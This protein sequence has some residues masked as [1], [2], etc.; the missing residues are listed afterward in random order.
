MAQPKTMETQM[1][2]KNYTTDVAKE[3]EAEWFEKRE[4]DLF[5]LYNQVIK[6]LIS[7]YEIEEHRAVKGGGATPRYR[8]NYKRN[9]TDSEL[10]TINVSPTARN[11]EVRFLPR[12][13]NNIFVKKHLNQSNI[14]LKNR[15][16]AKGISITG[17][18]VTIEQSSDIEFLRDVLASYSVENFL[19]TP[20]DYISDSTKITFQPKRNTKRMI[21]GK[22]ITASQKELELLTRFIEWLKDIG[23]TNIYPEQPCNERD[24]IDVAFELKSE[25]IIAELKSL[26][27]YNDSAK[28]AIRT[29]LG[30]LLDYQY[31]DR[32]S[33]K[34]KLWIVLDGNISKKEKE[35]ISRINANHKL[36]IAIIFETE[37][38]QFHS[39]P[40]LN[41]D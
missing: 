38:L 3:F 25:R 18:E 4:E 35:F 11:I 2:N 9:S 30:Q 21:E 32:D 37:K 20:G 23:S 33:K 26:S 6:Y 15:K 10:I 34:C 19:S 8:F 5:S 29:A 40:K 12:I 31:F 16:N 28:R 7:Q 17:L 36:S 39:F 13:T 1:T 14:Q 24:R 22:E 41:I 27:S